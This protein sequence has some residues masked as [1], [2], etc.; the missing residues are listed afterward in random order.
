[1]ACLLTCLNKSVGLAVYGCTCM[2]ACVIAS[3]SSF[4]FPSSFVAGWLAGCAG[5]L[6]LLQ[7]STPLSKF[8]VNMV[9]RCWLRCCWGLCL[10]KAETYL[11]CSQAINLSFTIKL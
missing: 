9:Y 3:C 6:M 7:Q 1:M 5:L 2:N 10:L 4:D 11:K 8:K